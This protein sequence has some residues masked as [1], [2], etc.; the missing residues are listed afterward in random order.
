MILLF[1]LA[2]LLNFIANPDSGVD[3]YTTANTT[4]VIDMTMPTVL[5]T[6]ANRG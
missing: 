5:I 2:L 4:S 1:T 6:G 3:I